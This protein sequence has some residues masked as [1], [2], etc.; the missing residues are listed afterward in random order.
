MKKS[1][2]KRFAR[3]FLL[4]VLGVIFITN[5]ISNYMIDKQF[6]QYLLEENKKKIEKVKSLVEELYKGKDSFE[7]LDNNQIKRY[8]MLEDL[9]I[10]I[11]D[12]DEKM[13]FSSGENHLF[14][15][16]MMGNMMGRKYDIKSGE[17][18]E[19][20]FPILKNGETIGTIV[21]GYFG[22]LNASER[23]VGFKNTMNQSFLISMIITLI[24]GLVTSLILSKQMVKSLKKITKVA[25][26]MK[27]GNLQIRS[28][29]NTNT[30]EIDQLSESI[31]FLAETLQQQDNLR[32]RLTSDMAHEIRTPLT[33]LQ[34][35]I[36]ALIDGIWEVTPER[37]KSCHEEILRLKKLVEHLKDLARLEQDNL[38]LNKS[39]FNLST[40]IKKT[41]ETFKPQYK[42]KDLKLSIDI[43]PKVEVSMDED[44]IKQILFNLLSN[45][46]KYSNIGGQVEIGLKYDEEIIIFVKDEGIGISK[47][48]LPYIFERFY[49]GETS[50]SRETGGAG[51]GLAITKTLVEAHNGK[52]EV[53][54]EEREGSNF[55][56]KFSKKYLIK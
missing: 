27:N 12:E 53:R 4:T 35:H 34:T 43:L 9:Y 23:D 20:I 6:D 18:I 50:R 21:I 54:S 3:N 7:K 32:K 40:T 37:L 29:V 52:I 11:N 2:T 24:F 44:K 45:A 38:Y 10:Q 31:N 15:K 49:R 17:Y 14:H 42:K 39:N 26:E 55:I 19:K 1:L 47:Q 22:L 13:I 36:E 51:I 16:K 56:I 46:Y 28:K 33:T 5:I 8:A 25:N 30:I 48:D 41:I